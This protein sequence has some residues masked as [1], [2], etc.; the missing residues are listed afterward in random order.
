MSM[1]KKDIS[2]KNIAWYK[3]L[4]AKLI[5][6]TI[7][8]ILGASFLTSGLIQPLARSNVRELTK[9]YLVDSVNNIS[10]SIEG[11]DSI[12]LIAEKVNNFE[13]STI[14]GC[15]V[16]ILDENS[17]I[18]YYSGDSK[19]DVELEIKEIDNAVAAGNLDKYCEEL[20]KYKLNN[21]N[22]EAIY[23]IDS[24]TKIKTILTADYDR[25]Y[26]GISGISNRTNLASI[27]SLL[28][29]GITSIII[30]FRIAKAV[31][32]TTDAVNKLSELSLDKLEQIDTVTKHEDE[33]GII[34]NSVEKLREILINT[35]SEIKE[36][37]KN[38][39][40]T[41]ERLNDNSK[42]TSLMVQQIDA[43]VNDIAQGASSQSQDTMDATNSVVD[44][45]TLIE[46]TN[47]MVE[48]LANYAE[49]MNN[50]SNLAVE[51]FREL[52]S[53]NIKTK[54]AVEIID[55]QTT[56]TSESADR[57]KEVTE[58][59]TSIAAQTNL[60]ALNA[61]IEAARAGEAGRGFAVVAG[62][63]GKLAD[64]SKQSA[65]QIKEIIDKLVSDIQNSVDAMTELNEIVEKQDL[66]I[67]DT[68]EQFSSVKSNIDN[69]MSKIELISSKTKQL[70]TERENVTSIVENLSA[71]SEENAASTEETSA[72]VTQISAITDNVAEEASELDEIAKT[73]KESVDKFTF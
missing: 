41:A 65:N 7:V 42:E 17:N 54:E 39:T 33:V 61:S 29:F 3:S 52:A 16:I 70:N 53:S 6:L 18:I 8:S 28:F 67:K 38:V 2:N 4:R 34:A 40:N 9:G 35:I 73:L 10:K 5:T 62:E 58:M 36:L 27:L 64:Q 71:I 24:D 11:I 21:I 19:N 30:S 55:K 44:M 63:I 26:S 49:E 56:K 31:N 20:V 45:A 23:R 48:E 72:S 43:A 37:S 57:I 66:S 69:S 1:N 25:M 32:I 46:E 12:D 13:M 47:I 51:S 60:L 50:S 22:K 68:N 14:D 15:S 59:I